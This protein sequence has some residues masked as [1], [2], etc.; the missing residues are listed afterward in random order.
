MR[1]FIGKRLLDADDK[2]RVNKQKCWTLSRIITCTHAAI[3]LSF[4]LGQL[5]EARFWKTLSSL[6]SNSEVLSEG[7]YLTLMRDTH[8]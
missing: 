1:D 6:M 8:V 4:F 5:F 3:F 7:I 2:Q